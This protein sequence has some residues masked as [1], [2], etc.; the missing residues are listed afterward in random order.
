MI[1]LNNLEPTETPEKKISKLSISDLWALLSLV[2]ESGNSDEYTTIS[3]KVLMISMELDRRYTSIFRIDTIV[4]KKESLGVVCHECKKSDAII[5]Y[6]QH[7]TFPSCQSC[8]DKLNKD[9]DNEYK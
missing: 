4:P 9:F 7:N 3:Q 5:Y 1:D 2:K 6:G 8:F